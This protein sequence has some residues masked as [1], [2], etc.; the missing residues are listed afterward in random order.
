MTPARRL[1]WARCL[2]AAGLVLSLTAAPARAYDWLQ[3][4]GDPQHSSRNSL[5]TT[6]TKANVAAL[7]QKYSVSIGAT[8][9][10]AP[11]F[12][13]GVS[14][15]SG[16][17]DLVFVTTTDGRIVAADAAT[18]GI[19]WS[20]Q[21]GPGTCTINKGGSTCY[22]T[23]S[24]AIDP[25][26]LYVYSYGLDGFVHKY[27]VGS[28]TEILA[29]GWPQLTTTKGYD[30]KGSSAISFAT[31]ADGTTYLYVVHGG[32]PGDNGDYQG[33]VT[34]INVAT[35]AQIVFNT[36]CSDQAVHFNPFGGAAPT[37][38]S[39][40]NAIW[41]RPGV[42]YDAGTDRIFMGTGNGTFSGNSGGHNWS[43]SVI[44]LH[45]DGSGGTGANAGKPV[46]SYTP[47]NYQSL[48]GGDTDVGSTAPAILPVPL[49]SAVQHL[50][51]QSG[52]DGRL[53]LINLA[54]LSGLGGPGHLMGDPGAVQ[55]GSIIN[56]PQGG[57]VLSQPAVWV[58]PAD[59][60]TWVFV[61]NNNGSAAYK[62]VFDGSGNPSLSLQWNNGTGGT[63]PLVANN[64]LFS[65]GGN[66]LRA[67]DPVNGNALWS[68]S[69]LGGTHWH[70]PIVANGSVYVTDGSA[71]LLR[72]AISG[73]N[74]TTTA[75]TSSLTPSPFGTNVTFTATI[76][77]G[78]SPAGT[79]SFT[80]SGNAIAGCSNV[81]VNAAK[82]TCAT[83]AL[84]VG[85]HGIVA[86]YSGDASNAGSVSPT[87]TQVVNAGASINVA[88][89]TNG[90]VA[91]AS[92]TYVAAGVSFPVAAVN[93]GD[94]SGAGWGSGGG[95]N[96]ATASVFPDWVQIN[97]S[98]Q[99]TIDHVVVVTLQDNYASPVQPTAS[100]PFTLYG[101]TD[102]SVQTWNGSAWITQGTVIGNNL[103]MRT[104]TFASPVTTDRI[105]VNITNA[106]L[107][108]SRLVEVEA[109]TSGAAPPPT[110]TVV[111]SSLTPSTFGASVTFTATI[112]GA[113][114]TGTVGFTDNGNA[115]AGCS[116]VSVN[117]ATATC[118]T[119]TLAV[120]THGIVA[121]YS[122][123][124]ANAGSVS[125][126]LTQVVN[127]GA[128]INVALAANGGVA[129][130]SSTYVAAG[131]SFPVAAINNGDRSGAGWGSGGGW[132]DATG[133]VFPDWVQ[134]NFSGSKTID[135]VV[136]VTLQDNYASPVQPTASTPFTLY[137]VT[138]FSVQTWNGSAWITQGTVS[139]NSLVMRTV[140]FASAVTTDRIRVNITNAKLVYSRL[141]EV[142][143]WGN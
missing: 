58:N 21:N 80:D 61:V 140:T 26:R 18:G 28:G 7:T 75:V 69:A 10:G 16:I 15:S 143:A 41:S 67:R 138:D 106:K 19:V 78:V 87:F 96:D 103:V 12:L 85:T 84:A 63:S 77:G 79:I 71:H 105:R 113:S 133:S 17:K 68:S 35:G 23:S 56:L 38:A 20:H 108:Y 2:C 31:A 89:A 104:V 129:S 60:T 123:D 94:R 97:F 6:I 82:A 34:A 47:A 27:Q 81:S 98:G 141:V 114:P 121:T 112:T 126:T 76:S 118:A 111:T 43:E 46:D 124:A 90:G 14:T 5:E 93:N 109:W 72:F 36:A 132:N 88:L 102:F 107:V 25:N 53:R 50:A 116:N 3:F 127:S 9:D 37:C 110:A 95:W 115:I 49:T 120:G 100:T 29:G 135:H 45:A 52:K 131:V 48:D 137:G 22:T 11:V 51:V 99:K 66:T 30:E 8:A 42:I 128:Q 4:G 64:V 70:S 125:P 32:Y 62:L 117:A 13:E 59:G 101:V 24:P 1:P 119:A 142:E 91:S 134:I 54:N 92:S 57:E 122:G 74:P 73:L 139:A 33:H 55:V 86:T 39:V 65:V 40:R 130:A 83:S 44:A 136:V